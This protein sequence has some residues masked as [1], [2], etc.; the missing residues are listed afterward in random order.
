MILKIPARPSGGLWVVFG[1][2]WVSRVRVVIGVRGFCR[3][4]SV[5]RGVDGVGE[6]VGVPR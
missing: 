1:R 5:Q 3:I 6:I 4:D 2:L